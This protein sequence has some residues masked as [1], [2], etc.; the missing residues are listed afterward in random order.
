MKRFKIMLTLSLAVFCFSATNAQSSPAAPTMVI[1]DTT[2]FYCPMKCE[3]DKTY[4]KAGKCPKCGMKLKGTPKTVEAAFQCP[5]KCEGNKTYAAEGKCPKCN[6]NLRKVV[7]S[8]KAD[9]DHKDH[10]KH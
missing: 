1:I 6:M 2:T 5:M 8:K 3:G 10:Q 9:H 4:D 7:A